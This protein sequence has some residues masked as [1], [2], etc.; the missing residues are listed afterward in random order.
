[1][2]IPRRA[3]FATP[4]L[5]LP[6]QAQ[7]AP[8]AAL[9]ARHGGQL[10]V[11]VLDTGSGR[12]LAHRPDERFP[13]TSTFKFLAAALVLARV[14]AGEERLDRHLA[15]GE[16]AL[17][18]Y[19]PVTG[20]AAARGGL[21]IGEACEA[22]VILSDNTAGNLMLDSFG[23]PAGLT[24]W[25]RRIGDAETRLDRRE[26]ELNEAAPGDP[27]DT[28]TPAAM[29][30]TMRKLLLG[31]VLSPASRARLL[32]GL[33]ACRTGDRRLRAG[34]PAGWRAGDKTGSGNRNA[35][36]DIAIAHPPGRA[37]LLVAAYYIGAEAPMAQREAV[38]AEVGRLASA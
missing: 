32:G 38:L 16:S 21:T 5:T 17:V 33:E 9:E 23:G 11:A 31:E 7:P 25:L 4:L 15:Y 1:M 26:T 10:G 19:S 20:P 18:T 22:A 24:A 29:L 13:L 30:A 6:A 37:P 36:N 12:G 34:F 14:D 28:T 3:L 27:R 8:F 35:T 2:P